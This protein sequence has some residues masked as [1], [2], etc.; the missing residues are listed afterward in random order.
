MLYEFLL[1]NKVNQLYI[2][3]YCLPLELRYNFKRGLSIG[4]QQSQV[5][6]V[7]ESYPLLSCKS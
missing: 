5:T 4:S 6:K 2:Y 1:Y 3:T 7:T